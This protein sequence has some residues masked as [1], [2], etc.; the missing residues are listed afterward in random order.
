MA[1]VS[2]F[3]SQLTLSYGGVSQL[4]RKHCKHR[5]ILIRKLHGHVRRSGY[6]AAALTVH[7]HDAV[8]HTVSDK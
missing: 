4:H 5:L 1:L 2:E 7:R 3:L 8:Y 6:R